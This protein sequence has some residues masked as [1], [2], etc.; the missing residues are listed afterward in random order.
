MRRILRPGGVLFLQ[1]WPF[2][3]SERGSHLW[4]WFPQPHHHLLEHPREI[5]EQMLASDVHDPGFTRYMA[6]E[7]ERLNRI[8]VEQLHRSL[9]AAGFRVARVELMTGAVQLPPEL[10]RHA[11][12]DLAISGIKLLAV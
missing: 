5:V 7:F 1:L 2:Y 3:F 9:L 8:T 11:L 10:S 4:D 6:D 12:A